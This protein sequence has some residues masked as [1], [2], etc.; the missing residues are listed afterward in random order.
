MDTLE[1]TE[2][3]IPDIIYRAAIGALILFVALLV[4][5]STAHA[6]ELVPSIGITRTSQDNADSKSYYGF[7]FRGNLLPMFKHE[8]AIGYRSEE[9]TDPLGLLT[10]KMTTVPITESIWFQPIPLVYA[11]AGVGFYFSSL[12]YE[13]VPVPETQE[14]KFGYH[15]GGGVN[16]PLAPMIAVDLQGRYV[17]M[18]EVP[19]SLPQGNLDPDFWSTSVGIAIKF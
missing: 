9:V 11:G 12:T 14:R 8:S 15:I 1:P 6:V 17:F 5:I 10:L 13:N 4:G 7:A 18:D 2:R 16:F 3:K 19:T